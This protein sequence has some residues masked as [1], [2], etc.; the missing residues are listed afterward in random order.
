MQ[1]RRLSTNNHLNILKLVPLEFPSSFIKFYKQKQEM[2]PREF[3]KMK[4]FWRW[5]FYAQATAEAFM[6][7][8]KRD[9]GGEY[10]TLTKD[11]LRLSVR[12]HTRPFSRDCFTYLRC[13]ELS[14]DTL[15]VRPLRILFQRVKVTDCFLVTN[16]GEESV[17]EKLLRPAPFAFQEC[18]FPI[19][20]DFVHVAFVEIFCSTATKS[21]ASFAARST[22]SNSSKVSRV[23]REDH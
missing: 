20:E 8:S 1:I 14:W 6:V 10:R 18:F 3:L 23:Q 9:L 19:E 5:H 22:N 15:Y 13:L 17:K 4:K 7:D 21:T 12:D 2:H 16:P 11:H